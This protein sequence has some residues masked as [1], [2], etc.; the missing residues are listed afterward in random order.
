MINVNWNE[1]RA[2]AAWLS[3]QTGQS[4]RL[5]SEAEWEYAARAGITTA[6]SF[7]A[8]IT[9]SQANYDRFSGGQCN[10]GNNDSLARTVAAGSF[11]ANAFGLYDMHGNV[12]EWVEDCYVNTYNGAPSDGSARTTGCGTTTRV[13]ARG[14]AWF[15]LAKVLRSANRARPRPTT[16]ND[17]VGFRLVQDLNP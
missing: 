6:Y 2:Y 11:P 14:G 8:G 10:R 13:V 1:A 15:E 9:C 17:G 7:G 4:Y 5:P 3:A 16:R 12:Y